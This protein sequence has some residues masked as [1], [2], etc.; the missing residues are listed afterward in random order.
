MSDASRPTF[1][2]I[3][4]RAR[5]GDPDAVRS[6]FPIVYDELRRVA[7]AQRAP[8]PQETLNTTALVHEAYLRLAGSEHI[9]IRDRAHFM[10]VAA[11][12][13]RQVLIDRARARFAAKRG[14]GVR[15]ISF[16]EIEAAVDGGHALTEERAEALLALDD[17]LVR[18]GRR[19]E[20]QCR[21]V[22]CR[23]YA[24]L[25]IEETARALGVSQATV[26]RDWAMAQ[27][28]LYSDLRKAL[29]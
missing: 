25:S 29:P 26:K 23:F 24:G 5:D 17:A 6:L 13:M 3:L 14:G 16:E 28:W 18:L 22:E 15:A 10:A 21:I 7:R 12:A 2:A 11:R 8:R 4:A 27:A 1:T 19:S 20:R 9:E